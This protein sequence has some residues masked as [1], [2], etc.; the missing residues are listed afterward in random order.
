MSCSAPL[1]CHRV[2]S[3]IAR[4][5]GGKLLLLH[6]RAYVNVSFDLAC[7]P[8]QRRRLFFACW[9]NEDLCARM[10]RTVQALQLPSGRPVARDRLHMTLVFLGE[11][12]PAL[13]V[14]AEGV[15][16]RIPMPAGLQMRLT[17][18]GGWPGPRVMWIA[19][20][21]DWQGLNSFVANLRADLRQCG[22]HI[23]AREFRPHVTVQRKISGPYRRG[24]ID[25]IDWSLESFCLVESL[26]GRAGAEY[27]VRRT[28]LASE[29]HHVI[30][31]SMWHNPAEIPAASGEE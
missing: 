5:S 4:R 31:S 10:V 22:L 19:P 6:C 17:R 26:T 2:F 30:Q 28:W 3:V 21:A 20:D 25:S 16:D 14:V 12:P 15:A 27:R 24:A 29:S 7:R 18:Y 8:V 23:E 9:P 1:F 11:I 13:Q